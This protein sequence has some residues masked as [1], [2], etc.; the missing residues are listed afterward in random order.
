MR[1]SQQVARLLTVGLI[2][3]VLA[4]AGIQLANPHSYVSELVARIAETGSGPEA[5]LTDLTSVDQLKTTFNRDGG[6]PR[7]VLLFSPT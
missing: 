1:S 6:H 2:V 7:L 5:S 4:V 3:A